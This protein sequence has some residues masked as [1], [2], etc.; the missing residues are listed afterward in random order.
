MKKEAIHWH[1]YKQTSLYT[2]KLS[3]L[4]SLVVVILCRSLR[5]NTLTK[6]RRV[7]SAQALHKTHTNSSATETNT[8]NFNSFSQHRIHFTSLLFRCFTLSCIFTHTSTQTYTHLFVI[9]SFAF[10]C[11]IHVHC[12][13]DYNKKRTLILV[14]EKKKLKLIYHRP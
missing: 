2:A 13:I 12:T 10:G 4:V 7:F 1:S 5:S 11:R 9:C 3:K 8:T 6:K 14:D